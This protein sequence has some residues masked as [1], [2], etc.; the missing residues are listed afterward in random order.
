MAYVGLRIQSRR[1][2]T[3]F[4]G[5]SALSYLKDKAEGIALES[6]PKRTDVGNKSLALYISFMELSLEN[7][8]TSYSLL[9]EKMKWLCQS[10]WSSIVST[11]ALQV[12]GNCTRKLILTESQTEQ[13]FSA[14]LEYST[15]IADI[16]LRLTKVVLQKHEVEGYHSVTSKILA[17]A[18]SVL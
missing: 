17:T 12:R 14:K 8:S 5:C 9:G 11:V 10:R 7:M 6:W 3:R 4:D 18:L 2:L 1:S 16:L 13:L 15:E